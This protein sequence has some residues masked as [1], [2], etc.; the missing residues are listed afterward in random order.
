MVIRSAPFES[1]SNERRVLTEDMPGGD[2]RH[3]VLG[4]PQVLEHLRIVPPDG[5]P[6]S[7]HQIPV[8]RI[9]GEE[10]NLRLLDRPAIDV[11]RARSQFARLVRQH[12][13]EMDGS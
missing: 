1:S 13:F 8:P 11:E 3:Q 4:R 5:S 6:Y 12:D 9:G 7:G 2:E 10:N